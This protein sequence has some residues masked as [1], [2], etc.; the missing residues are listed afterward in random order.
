MLTQIWHVNVRND[1]GA[2]CHN[3]LSADPAKHGGYTPALGLSGVINGVITLFFGLENANDPFNLEAAQ[4]Y[5][6]D[7]K[8]Y[9]RQAIEWT[10][11][12]AKKV[13]IPECK[14][15]MKRTS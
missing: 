14:K 10:E 1:T 13:D 3:Y 9:D 4:Q 7:R 12:Y 8:A 2:I 11:K 5:L 6:E 15:A